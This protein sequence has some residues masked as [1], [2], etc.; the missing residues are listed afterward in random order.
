VIRVSDEGGGRETLLREDAVVRLGE[1]VVLDLFG[2][3]PHE[4][5]NGKWCATCR[6]EIRAEAMLWLR[7]LNGPPA[8]ADPADADYRL[9]Y[10]WNENTLLADLSADR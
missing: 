1:A 2:Q 7:E 6:E 3:R 5:G 8:W 10:R 4:C 9:L